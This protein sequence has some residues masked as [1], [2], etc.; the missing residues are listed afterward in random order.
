MSY[1]S[2][3]FERTLINT[4]H[5]KAEWTTRNLKMLDLVGGMAVVELSGAIR[6]AKQKQVLRAISSGNLSVHDVVELCVQAASAEVFVV[7]SEV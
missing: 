1:I 2:H 5:G 7:A 3:V 6:L 4:R